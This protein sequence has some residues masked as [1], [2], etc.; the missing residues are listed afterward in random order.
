MKKLSIK[1][2]EKPTP[3]FWKYIADFGLLMIPTVQLVL[4]GAPEGTF[5][6]TQSWAISSIVSVTAVAFKFLTK[7]MGGEEDENNEI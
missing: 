5:T 4:G 2:Y 7:L 6:S 3:K 1:N